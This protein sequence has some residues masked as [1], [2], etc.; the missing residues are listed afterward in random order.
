MRAAGAI[1]LMEPAD[2]FYG[3]R[4][5]GVKDPFGNQWWF[6]THVEDVSPDELQRRM[7]A[8]YEKQ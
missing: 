2:Q 8:F 4:S 3:D 1:S 5:A 7:K 6:S